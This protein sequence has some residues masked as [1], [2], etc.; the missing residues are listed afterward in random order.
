MAEEAAD[1]TLA[2]KILTKTDLT[3]DLEAFSKNI[4]QKLMER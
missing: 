1:L 3:T 4:T 2:V